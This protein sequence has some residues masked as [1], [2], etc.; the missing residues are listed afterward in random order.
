[1]SG[2]AHFVNVQNSVC[3]IQSGIT[4]YSSI[5]SF[6]L[7]VAIAIHIFVT[8]VYRN[9]V[10]SSW[11]YLLISNLVSW[12][13]PGKLHFFCQVKSK[14]YWHKHI[15]MSIALK[16]LYAHFPCKIWSVTS[17]VV[18]FSKDFHL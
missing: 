6:Y 2:I 18:F 8:V 1:M 5:V 9:D 14:V 7:T 4:T 3:I 16:V 17:V 15:Y 12:I 13:C 10:T 11:H